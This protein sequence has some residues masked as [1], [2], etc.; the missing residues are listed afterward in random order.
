MSDENVYAEFLRV[1]KWKIPE[2]QGCEDIF[3]S[4]SQQ[5]NLSPELIKKIISYYFLEIK[6]NLLSG[7][8]IYLFGL[9]KFFISSPF[10]S[11]G[12]T[13]IYPNFSLATTFRRELNKR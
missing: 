13:K 5:T 1:S 3:F 12:K 6:A 4:I 10:F 2:V 9:G 8:M 7:K 11:E